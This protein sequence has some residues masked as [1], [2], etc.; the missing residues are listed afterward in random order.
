MH[1]ATHRWHSA[2][3]SKDMDLAVYGH[4]GFALVLFP[5]SVSDYLEYERCGMID[6]LAPLIDSG[7]FK[8]FAVNSVT[9]E[10]WLNPDVLPHQ[11]ALRHQQYNAYITEEV[12]PFVR[13]HTSRDTMIILSGA[14]MGAYLGANLLFRRPD[15]FDGVIAMSGTYDVRSFTDSYHDDNCYFN[16]PVDYLPNLDD[17]GI[18]A[19]LR[20]KK[21]I[22][23]LSGQGEHESP[24]CSVQLAE[25]L[26]TKQIPCRLD[27][28]GY[29]IPH[30][31]PAWRAMLSHVLS[32]RF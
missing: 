24:E 23:I 6:T 26:R 19:R 27:L 1:R 8:V 28:W 4:W 21:H 15:I 16:S 2:Y 20:A 32:T 29:D 9:G 10:S 12:V 18:L 25:I 7:K 17:A 31:W 11:R 3:L 5:T 30:D 22:Y 13:S 14:S